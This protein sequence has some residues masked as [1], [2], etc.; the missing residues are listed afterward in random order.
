MQSTNK[1]SP[2]FT[3]VA[4]RDISSTAVALIKLLLP[5][6]IHVPVCELQV[7]H[8]PTIA[9]FTP[10]DEL[11]HSS[12]AAT[13]CIEQRCCTGRRSPRCSS[14]FLKTAFKITYNSRNIRVSCCTKSSYLKKNMNAP[15]PSEHP[16]SG[17]KMSKRL[18]GI[19]GCKYETSSWYSNGF[20]MVV[21]EATI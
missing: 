4:F 15:R 19:V 20:P 9:G 21:I 7:T 1:V 8:R 18:G 14:W 3:A 6:E 2:S 13:W 10:T 11:R 17:G 5:I 12:I 16:V